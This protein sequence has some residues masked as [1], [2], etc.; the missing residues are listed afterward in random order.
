MALTE[1]V[2]TMYN[3]QGVR[4]P[5]DVTWPMGADG[6]VLVGEFPTGP[7]IRLV[8]GHRGRRLGR[9]HAARAHSADQPNTVTPADPDAWRYG[10]RHAVEQAMPEEHM[11]KVGQ[12]ETYQPVVRYSTRHTASIDDY[13]SDFA[14][15]W[16]RD[17]TERSVFDLWLHVVDHASRVGR[18]IRLDNPTGVIDDLADTAVWLMSFVAQCRRSNNPVDL[19]FAFT[20]TTSDLIWNKFPGQCASCFDDEIA[21]LAA[22][23]GI[24]EYPEGPWDLHEAISTWLTEKVSTYS[25]PGRCNCLAR[26]DRYVARRDFDRTLRTRLDKA[27]HHYADQLQQAGHKPTNIVEFENMFGRIFGSQQ[28]VLSLQTIAFHLLE[29]VGD[30]TQAF[31]DCYT[32]DA[33][34]EAFNDELRDHRRQRLQEEVADIFSWM[35]AMTLKV[36]ALYRDSATEYATTLVPR[37]QGPYRREDSFRFS[38]VIWSKYGTA[39]DGGHW[40]ALKCPGCEVAPCTCPRDLKIVWSVP[41]HSPQ[42]P[43]TRSTPPAFEHHGAAGGEARGEVPLVSPVV[44]VSPHF[45]LS[46][47]AQ[48]VSQAEATNSTTNQ[49]LDLYRLAAGDAVTSPKL[50]DSITSLE[51]EIRST[52][53]KI[54]VI[55]DLVAEVLRRSPERKRA[56]YADRLRNVLGSLL[57]N[58]AGNA[59]VAPFAGDLQRLIS[60]IT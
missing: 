56:S 59:A 10:H 19:H 20:G 52:T 38:D 55:E 42:P 22:S 12:G 53:P 23:E 2:L 4:I 49:L 37:S 26:A 1:V 43:D 58:I 60:Q 5:E 27:R 57:L 33:N 54:D 14:Q 36:K 30:A 45:V 17:L 47:E 6:R 50:L 32:F 16:A 24:A 51:R 40:E 3:G 31:K 25:V 13:K 41:P 8:E 39:R 18:A 29:E 9:C 46:S 7:G 35:F 15:I 34:R 11:A 48:A 21:A 28:R 44:V